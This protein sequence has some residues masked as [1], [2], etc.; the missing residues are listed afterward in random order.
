MMN[1][2]Y[3]ARTRLSAERMK[4]RPFCAPELTFDFHLPIDYLLSS[5]LLRD[6]A[7]FGEFPYVTVGRA[8]KRVS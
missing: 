7:C 6:T 4:I 1:V 5:L 2:G 3:A 8:E